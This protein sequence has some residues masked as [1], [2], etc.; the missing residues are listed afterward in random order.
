[1][2]PVEDVMVSRWHFIAALGQSQRAHQTVAETVRRG[3]A[4][5]TCYERVRVKVYAYFQ[6]WHNAIKQLYTSSIVHEDAYAVYR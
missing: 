2:W 1:M 5:G 4:A 3:V 6:C